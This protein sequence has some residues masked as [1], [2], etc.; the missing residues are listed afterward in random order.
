MTADCNAAIVRLPSTIGQRVCKKVIK[1][2]IPYA[3]EVV[4]DAEDGWKS[5]SSKFYRSIWKKIDRDMRETCYKA[6]GVSCVT[7]FYM[8]KHYYSKKPSAFYSHYSSLALDKSFFTSERVFPNRPMVVANVANQ[9][10]F[11]GRKGFKEIIKALSLLKERGLDV[12]AAFAGKSYNDGEGQL[13]E[14][15]ES[16]GVRDKVKFMGYLS[17]EEMDRFLNGVDI[18]VMPTKAEGLPR[19][20]IEAMA[21]GLPAIS[22]PVSGNPE[23]LSSH[24]LVGFDDVITLADRIEE[25][26][27]SPTLYEDASKE[28]FK[29]SLKYEASILEE[30]RD[31]FYTKLKEV[32]Q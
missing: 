4:Y 2:K 5:I 14:Y 27:T 19:V 12:S 20:I 11:N 3:V 26:S 25:L 7:E 24:F 32:I 8:Q 17:R 30:R 9:I 31:Q 22:T 6:D 18:F 1:K 16:L 29:N 28:N 21:K 23:L 15:A 10:S 13:M